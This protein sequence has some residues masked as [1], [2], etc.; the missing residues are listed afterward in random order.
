MIHIK[1]NYNRIK[2]KRKYLYFKQN[3][4]PNSKINKFMIDIPTEGDRPP[5]I[6]L[7]FEF[8]PSI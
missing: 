3:L 2:K 7:F 1:S 4:L 5:L 8:I 6:L